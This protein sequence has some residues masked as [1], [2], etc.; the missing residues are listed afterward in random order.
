M[1]L[2]DLVDVSAPQPWHQRLKRIA[3]LAA[4]A[5]VVPGGSLIVAAFIASR[6]QKRRGSAST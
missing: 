5:I 3:T 2:V 6:C 4:F 1:K